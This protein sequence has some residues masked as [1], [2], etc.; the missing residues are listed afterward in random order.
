VKGEGEPIR[1]A[2]DRLGEDTQWLEGRGASRSPKA[3][4]QQ[5]AR[6]TAAVWK[7]CRGELEA[8]EVSGANKKIPMKHL[9]GKK[10]CSAMKVRRPTAQM[11]CL[12]TN[13]CS[14]GNKQEELEAIV[15][16]E[17]YNLIAITETWWDESH[18]WNIALDGYRLF[19]RDRR[20]RRGGGV[21]L[22]IKKTL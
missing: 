14:M 12:Y 4:A 10:G 6:D 17:S 21:A 2:S 20:G 3:V 1:L 13:A 22:Y 16:L 11:K 18:D 7:S 8:P 15:L 5:H 19:R 9:K